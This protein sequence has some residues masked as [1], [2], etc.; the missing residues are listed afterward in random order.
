MVN[1]NNNNETENNTESNIDVKQEQVPLEPS[2]EQAADPVIHEDEL[3]ELA[4]QE[5]LASEEFTELSAEEAEA[6]AAAE[7]SQVITTLTEEEQEELMASMEAIL[8]MSD[9]PISLPKLRSIINAEIALKNYRILM[10]R[11]KDEFKKGFRGVEIVEVSLGFQLRTKPNMSS[12]LR[13]MVKTQPLKL[14]STNLEVLAIVAYKQPITKEEIDQV[15]GVDSGYVLR[16]LM[17]KRLVR[18][19]GRSEQVGRPM[20]YATTHEF[21]E[22]FNLKD[23]NELPP[24]H[25]VEAMVAANEV[26][27]E[28]A[29]EAEFKEFGTM[30]E[31]SLG[32][33]LFDDSKIDGELESIR[34]QISEIPT[35]TSFIDEQKA[36]HK[37]AQRLAELEAQGLLASD[38]A[39]ALLEQGEQV[40]AQHRPSAEL[41]RE[42][43]KALWERHTEQMQRAQTEVAQEEAQTAESVAES[44]APTEKLESTTSDFSFEDLQNA[45]ISS[46]SLENERLKE[47]E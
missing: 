10:M 2:A 40:V 33:I 24:L 16:N 7:A 29:R 12:V 27:D 17:E 47:L 11:L 34:Q 37:E 4:K 15:R 23:A 30:V 21:L 8:F 44:L 28:Q 46:E 5:G 19:S 14:S 13:K 3:L 38:Q 42:A 39:N 25:E 32:K 1:D 43:E 20:L 26:G 9:K 45:D 36:L 18:I 6:Q 22:I 35:S 41:L 31:N